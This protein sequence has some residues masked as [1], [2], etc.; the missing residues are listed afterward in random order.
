MAALEMLV[1]IPIVVWLGLGA[2]Q[3][4]LVFHARASI[5]FAVH[6]AARAASVAHA[7][8]SAA[9]HGLARGLLPFLYGAGSRADFEMNL[10]RALG[11][12]RAGRAG[13]WIRVTQISPTAQSFEDWGEA[14]LDDSG[15]PRDGQV[16]IPN[17]N[18]PVRSTSMQPA[19][20]AAGFRGREP[21]GAASGQTL[22]DANLLKLEAVYGVP[23]HVPLVGRLSAWIMQ[24]FDGCGVPAA[25]ALGL[26]SLREQA[27]SARAWTCA[28][29]ASIDERGRSVPRW[30]VRAAATV[31]M[32]SPARFDNGARRESA[33]VEGAPGGLGVVDEPGPAPTAAAPVDDTPSR[34]V[35]DSGTPRSSGFLRLGGARSAFALGPCS[36]P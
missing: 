26:V 17:D 8:A 7:D 29:Y 16:E 35:A 15:H 21:I 24:Q 20:G 12:V 27:V 2:W 19:S 3:W 33:A 14:A 10:A 18:L 11:H 5:A 22:L 30:P 4:A 36:V 31:R 28:F 9:E 25:R 6:E 23:L 34:T 32:Q 13:G 1:A